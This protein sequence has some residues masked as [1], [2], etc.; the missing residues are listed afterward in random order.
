MSKIYLIVIMISL[1]TF[2]S[3]DK[4]KIEYGGT[5][6]ISAICK[7]GIVVGMD[8]RGVFLKGDIVLAHFDSVQKVFVVRN[9]LMSVAGLIAI[10]DRFISSFIDEF[11]TTLPNE[12]TPNELLIQFHNFFLSRYPHFKKDFERL[13]CV[14]YGYVGDTPVICALDV[15]KCVSDSGIATGDELSNFGP[16]KEYDKIFCKGHSSDEV[17]NLIEE[18]IK[19]Y[20]IVNNKT[21]KVGGDIMLIKITPD[22]ISWIKNSPKK[23]NWNTTWDLIKEY[24]KG[25]VP[26]TFVSESYKA[27]FMKD[28][29]IE[30]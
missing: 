4:S 1:T 24:K 27:K 15:K 5:Y 2:E 23:K 30:K 10:G 12:I 20:A 25:N 16:G 21:E 7:D 6:F 18:S 11:E 28:N 9:C 14:S 8:T 13:R 17:A 3:N 22:K 29:P 19:Q 26:I